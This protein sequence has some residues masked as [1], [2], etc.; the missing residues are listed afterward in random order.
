MTEFRDAILSDEHPPEH[1]LLLTRSWAGDKPA[2]VVTFVGLNPSTADDKNDDMTVAKCRGFAEK[3]GCNAFH[4]VNLYTRR[5]TKPAALKVLAAINHPD[6]DKTIVD[7][8]RGVFLV[9]ACWGAWAG[10]DPLRADVVRELVGD[11]WHALGFTA[12]GGPRHPSRIAYSTELVRWPLE[13]S[14][15]PPHQH[16]LC[17][18]CGHMRNA[19]RAGGTCLAYIPSQQLK[20]IDYRQHPIQIAQQLAVTSKGRAHAS[21]WTSS[22]CPCPGF[23]DS[24]YRFIASEDP[25]LA[26]DVRE[27]RK[28]STIMPI[29]EL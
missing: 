5:A 22:V 4:V 15:T 18:R 17:D 23:V 27:G 1:R 10:P 25:Q 29:A 3:W 26:R 6:G 13:A 21:Q 16:D 19:H 24:G 14:G 11:R 9:V 8:T 2:K 7:Y 20:A 12:E 28:R